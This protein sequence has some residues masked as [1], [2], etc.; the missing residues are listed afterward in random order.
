M[1]RFTHLSD[2][3]SWQEQVHPKEIDLGLER[4][5]Q[6][7]LDLDIISPASDISHQYSGSLKGEH[8]VITVAGTNGKGSCIA[9]LEKCLLAQNKQVG[10]YTSPHLHHYC[11]RIRINGKPVSEEMVCDAFSAIDSARGSISLTYF[12]FGTLAALWI[13]IQEKVPYVL[14]EVGLGGRL[15][16]VNIIDTNIA[17]VTSIDLDHQDWLGDSREL[18]SQEKLGIARNSRPLIIAEANLTPSLELAAKNYPASLIERD[19]SLKE[20]DSHSWQLTLEGKSI[21]LP[22]PSLSLP[23]VA[24][25]LVALNHLGIFP[26]NLDRVMADISLPGRY[27]KTLINGITVVFDVAHNPAA[28][29][30]LAEKLKI[31]PVEGKTVALLSIMADKDLEGVVF[32]LTSQVSHWYL[33]TLNENNRA[34]DKE[35]LALILEKQGL[36]YTCED[37]VESSFQAALADS[38][39]H[40]RIVVF[41]SFFTVAAIQSIANQM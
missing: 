33:G 36:S 6:V 41:G 23:S 37:S 26:E 18:I 27:Q 17:V 10:C 30:L 25:A 16:A 8:T 3:L 32:P 4:I 29:N 22:L 39:Q 38:E 15:D 40:D 7:A 5:Y 19:Y 12:E 28:A 35:A 31:D 13:F 14:L 9:T 2:W 11:E 24:A 20:L 34:V 21:N 1:S